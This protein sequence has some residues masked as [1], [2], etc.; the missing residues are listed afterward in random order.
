MTDPKVSFIVPCRNKAHFVEKTAR[1]VLNQT[2]SP[3]EIVFSDQGSEDDTLDILKKLADEYTGPNTVRVLECPDT[4]YRGMAGLN[5][6]LNWIHTQIT[7]DLVIMC[8]ADD[9]NHPDRAKF[10]VEAFT[11][12]NPSYIGTCVQYLTGRGESKGFTAPARDEGWVDPVENIINLVGS[13]ASSCWSRDLFEKYGPLYGV[14]SQDILLPF[15]GTLERGL[16]YINVPLHIYIEHADANNTGLNGVCRA[17]VEA[18]EKEDDPVKKA[19]L[20]RLEVAAAEC[21]N[22]HFTSNYYAMV[23]KVQQ[24]G[25]NVK[26]EVMQAVYQKALDGAGGWAAARDLLTLNRTQP[27][28]MRI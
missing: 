25:V 14:E 16:F 15:F 3:M 1:S 19:E 21:N 4:E 28:L 11:K 6:H 2:Y 10:T 5:R 9:L 20:E 13:S 8:S 7:G 18:R 22:W 23:R 27:Q 12:Y 26:Q 24:M 17:A